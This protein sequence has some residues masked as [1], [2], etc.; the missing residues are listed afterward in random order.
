M[1]KE[2]VYAFKEEVYRIFEEMG[3]GHD[4]LGTIGI[5]G[6]EDE[7][8]DKAVIAYLKDFTIDEKYLEFM[9]GVRN[10]CA[11]GEQ[12]AVF[13]SML[14]ERDRFII[15]LMKIVQEQ[16]MINEVGKEEAFGENTR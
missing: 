6:E 7:E 8:E 12:R 10:Q 1:N 14:D 2:A 9:E 13:K 4:L 3:A 11:D 16:V 15:N 5:F